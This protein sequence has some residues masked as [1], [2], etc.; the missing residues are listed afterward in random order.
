MRPLFVLA[1]GAGAPSSSEWMRG[2]QARLETLGEVASF[3]YPY[4]ARGLKRPDRLPV[5]VAAHREAIQG[6]L[7]GRR[8]PVVL[9]GKSMGSRVG[10]HVAASGDLAIS[11]LICFGYP[12]VGQN[13]KVRDEVLLA[14]RTPV[15]F[16]Q[17]TR[18]RLCPLERLEE[19]R[20]EMTA[21]SELHVVEGG[22][23]SLLVTKTLLRQ[24]RRTQ[25]DEDS[26]I[27]LAVDRFVE[28]LRG[29]L[30]RP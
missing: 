30:D 28:T 9:A 6:A 2:W 18:D 19:T 29:A 14:L 1:H 11:G 27:L 12:L 16:V 25:A 22:D 15:L 7:G 5:L 20:A 21:R 4:M 3:D 8:L 13:G 10:C 17:G 26:A 24:Q 23:H